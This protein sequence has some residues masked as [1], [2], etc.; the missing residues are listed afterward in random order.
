M[1]A[2]QG[3]RIV[4]A[5]KSAGGPRGGGREYVLHVKKFYPTTGELQRSGVSEKGE[6]TRGDVAA[7]EGSGSGRP[8]ERPRRQPGR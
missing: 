7:G 2:A 6:G 4:Y 8:A 1:R 3:P 5:L